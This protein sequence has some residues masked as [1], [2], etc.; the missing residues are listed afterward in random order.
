MFQG[1]PHQ[2]PWGRYNLV[3][4]GSVIP[5]WFSHQSIGDEVSVQKKNSPLRNEW[6]GIAVC[7]L[8]CSNNHHPCDQI[9]NLRE[10]GCQLIAN[11]NHI[12]PLPGISNIAEVLSD[13]IW[14]L[15]LFPQHYDR[16][17]INLLWECDANGF[18]QIGIRIE[19][20][21]SGLRVKKCGFR[22]VYMKDIEDLHRTMVQSVNNSECTSVSFGIQE[23]HDGAGP[24][25]EDSFNGIS[26]CE[27]SSEY[28]E[29]GEEFSD[30][31]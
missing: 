10:L 12:Y 21:G 20:K 26:D 7:T 9:I 3:I 13:H 4:P 6:I 28:E 27:E 18:N 17:S 11:G 16:R 24:S 2:Y 14:L 30:S 23:T 31:D 5:R 19:T 1:L 8:F 22:L 25:E 15:Y 29:C